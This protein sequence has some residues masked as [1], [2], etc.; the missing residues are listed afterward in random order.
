M[1]GYLANAGL[2]IWGGGKPLDGGKIAKDGRRLFGPGKTIRGFFLGPL[3]FG[4]PIALII[5]GIVF[6]SWDSIMVAVEDFLQD[7]SVSY[8]FYDSNPD[9]LYADLRLYLLGD[10]NGTNNWDTFGKL[11]PRVVLCS[12]GAAMGDLAGSWYKRRKDVERGAPFWGVDQIDFLGGCL[13]L[14]FPL[15]LVGGFDFSTINLNVFI[16]L[17]IIT[18]SITVIANT[19]SY[20]TGHKDVPW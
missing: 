2:L 13:L 8:V 1:P 3:A 9:Q 4:V 6:A 19:I 7:P 10:A 11:V 18:P 5:H 20:V 17:F 12:F 16:M 15:L 14:A